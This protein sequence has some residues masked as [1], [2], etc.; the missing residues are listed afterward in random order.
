MVCQARRSLRAAATRLSAGLREWLAR[1]L[2]TLFTGHVRFRT[3]F[4]PQREAGARLAMTLNSDIALAPTLGQPGRQHVAEAAFRSPR[5]A[6]E[7]VGR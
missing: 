2:Q 1:N 7:F 6:L 3:N 5:Q 4:G